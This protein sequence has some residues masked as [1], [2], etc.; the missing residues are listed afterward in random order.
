MQTTAQSMSATAE[1]TNRQSVAVAVSAD[2][3]SS[4]VQNVASA[5]EA[6]LYHWERNISRAAQELS[7]ALA[8]YERTR[9]KVADA[10]D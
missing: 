8:R 4:N 3:A 1:E 7:S 6:L 9:G 5:A 10:C 2:Q